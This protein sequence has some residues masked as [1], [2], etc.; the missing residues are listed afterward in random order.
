MEHERVFECEVTEVVGVNCAILFLRQETGMAK[1]GKMPD[2][3]THSSEFVIA[4][5]PW[6][7]KTVIRKGNDTYT[8]YGW[9]REEADKNA[10]KKY[11]TGKKD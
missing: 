7:E 2:S 1:Q 3:V 11:K 4:P 6:L 5:T 10:G 9:S 8:G